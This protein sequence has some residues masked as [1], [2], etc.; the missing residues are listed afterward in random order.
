MKNVA[1]F[2][3][4]KYV[5]AAMDKLSDASIQPEVKN[6]LLSDLNNAKEAVDNMDNKVNRFSQKQVV[7][8]VLKRKPVLKILELLYIRSELSVKEIAGTL[9]ISSATATGHISRMEGLMLVAITREESILNVTIT[10]RGKYIL[11]SISN[12][13]INDLTS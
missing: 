10:S 2:Q 4:V 13:E 8:Y 7:D 11:D 12:V 6:E 5:N 3:V 9:G 1:K